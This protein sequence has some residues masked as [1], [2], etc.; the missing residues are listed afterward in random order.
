MRHL[1][2]RQFRTIA[3]IHA[4]G[5]II[6]ASKVLGLTAPA[7]TLQLKAAEAAA[8]VA[9]FQRTNR[10]MR[11]T[12]AGRAF[13][14]A[15]HAIDERL[16]L[17]RDEVEAIRGIKK[18]TM[19]LGVVSTAKYFAP[20]LIAAFMKATPGIAIRL[21]VGNRAETIANLAE[22]RVDIALMG[23]PPQDVQV[24]ASAFGDHPLVIVA[25]PDHPLA[26]RR[27]ISRQRIAQEHFLVRETGSGTRMS[28]E[29]FLGDLPGWLDDSGTEMESN[30][31]IKQAVI[32]GL[33]VA[34]IS[35]HTVAFEI[36]TGR[37]AVLDIVDL[38][39]MR[40]WY[41]VVR[42]DRTA[43][44]AVVAFLVFLAKHGASFLP[45]LP[46]ASRAR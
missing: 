37:L 27:R 41:S 3:S 16:R 12:D 22:Y 43:T 5:T 8:G 9:L 7:L 19:V 31:T 17:L 15:A 35:A 14:D 1:T 33:G 4:E 46:R 23:R 39:V 32:A 42:S 40:E 21:M 29:R 44:P 6:N 45:T 13:L 25:A 30:E 34:F 26:G 18:G 20:R 38:P 36:E 2:L 11:L 24:H 10:G 28:F